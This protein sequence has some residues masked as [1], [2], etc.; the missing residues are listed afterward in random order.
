MNRLA[1]PVG[2]FRIN[3][4]G[5]VL[6]HVSVVDGVRTHSSAVGRNFYED[7]APS[8]N[9]PDFRGRVEQL[10]DRKGGTLRFEFRLREPWRSARLDV[11]VYARDPNPIWLLISCSDLTADIPA[12][13]QLPDPASRSPGHSP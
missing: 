6:C 7:I 10:L 3:H 9:C 2:V 12:T 8:T 5:I 13:V 4:Q 1:L 11:R